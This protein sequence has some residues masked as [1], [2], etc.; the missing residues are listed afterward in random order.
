MGYKDKAKKAEA[1]R[2]YIAR[3]KAKDPVAWRKLSVSRAMDYQKRNPERTR[4][5]N[6]RYRENNVAVIMLRQAKQRARR[7]GLAF[8]L[9]VD[10]LVIPDY[11]PVLGI[12][13]VAGCKHSANSPSLDR[14]DPKLGYIKD[15]VRVISWRANSLK[16]NGTIEEF[17]Q[18]IAY[19][20]GD[21]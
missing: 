16:S 12:S 6:K 15:N 13:L 20:R 2:R 3:K 4:A 5:S 1:Q 9:C 19:M 10:E 11:C 17:E 7:F 21:L 8:D 18:I 14:F